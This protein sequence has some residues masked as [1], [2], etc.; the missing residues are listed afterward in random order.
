MSE[1]LSLMFPEL[2]LSPRKD[3]IGAVLSKFEHMARDAD[4]PIRAI[5][6]TPAC[7]LDPQSDLGERRVTVA[8]GALT[9]GETE[10]GAPALLS[11]VRFRCCRLYS[12]RD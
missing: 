8:V 5:R 10:R 12:A 4:G 3:D 1:S 2:P 9:P 7:D 6:R 11:L